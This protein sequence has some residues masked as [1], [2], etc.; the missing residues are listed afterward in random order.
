MH[1]SSRITGL[2]RWSQI[3][4]LEPWLWFSDCVN[5][6]THAIEW[7]LAKCTDIALSSSGSLYHSVRT[8]LHVYISRKNVALT[9]LHMQVEIWNYPVKTK[10]K[11]T[12]ISEISTVISIIVTTPQALCLQHISLSK[13]LMRCMSSILCDNNKMP[14]SMDD[15]LLFLSLSEQNPGHWLGCFVVKGRTEIER[16]FIWVWLS[17][18]FT[19]CSGSRPT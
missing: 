2:E 19:S 14:K 17:P 6:H 15:L 11:Y 5:R 3:I 8:F 13:S 4:P 9:E 1:L 16:K 10:K 7:L 12:K 18:L